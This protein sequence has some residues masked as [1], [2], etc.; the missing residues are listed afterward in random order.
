MGAVVPAIASAASSTIAGQLL[1]SVFGD[2]DEGP[3]LPPPPPQPTVQAA[4]PPPQQVTEDAE[5]QLADEQAR[6]RALRQR[7]ASQTRSRQSSVTRV[8]SSGQRPTLL[9]E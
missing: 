5:S 8:A 1:S 4:P 7:R 9:G 2:K 3:E 6:N